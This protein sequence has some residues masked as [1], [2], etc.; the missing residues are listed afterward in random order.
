MSC[1]HP[2][3]TETPR[4]R[5]SPENRFRTRPFEAAALAVVGSAAASSA[6]AAIISDDTR[7]DEGD[8][9]DLGPDSFELELNTG[10]SGSEINL[11]LNGGMGGMGV[12]PVSFAF[13]TIAGMMDGWLMDYGLGQTVDGSL[14]YSSKGYLVQDPNILQDWALGQTAY[15]G[16]SFQ[17]DAS[18]T[19]YGWIQLTLDS[20]GQNFHVSQWAYDST[21]EPIEIG[22]V[23]EP[24]TALLV[25]LGLAA[26]AK[27]SMRSS[28]G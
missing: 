15:A 6:S 24:N 5:R 1:P 8:T 27:K 19:A 16:F 2:T 28:G 3:L 14:G 17:Y 12:M 13:E 22:T 18:T 25:G 11:L 4:A 10:M 26:L 9:I 21:G 7:Y 20:G 23:P